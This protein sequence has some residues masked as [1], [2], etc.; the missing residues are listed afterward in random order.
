MPL[1]IRH[2]PCWMV[3]LIGKSY[4]KH[5]KESVS[6]KDTH[7]RCDTLD[8]CLTNSIQQLRATITINIKFNTGM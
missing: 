3:C 1:L 5:T 8:L 4:I 6:T 2:D 7:D